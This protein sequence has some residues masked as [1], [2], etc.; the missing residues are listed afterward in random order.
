MAGV[1]TAYPDGWR[2]LLFVQRDVNNVAV[3]SFRDNVEVTAIKIIN[4]AR[5][6]VYG[7]DTL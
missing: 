4:L 5:V 7:I 3:L 2:F 1:S 6:L